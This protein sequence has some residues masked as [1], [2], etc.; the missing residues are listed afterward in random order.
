VC[1]EID[2]PLI[3]LRSCPIESIPMLSSHMMQRLLFVSTLLTA[4][5]MMVAV[6]SLVFTPRISIFWRLSAY[7]ILEPARSLG[8]QSLDWKNQRGIPLRMAEG[9]NENDTSSTQAPKRR[10]KRK[11]VTEQTTDDIPSKDSKELPSVAVEAPTI[12]QLKPRDDTPVTME[13]L[14]IRDVMGE[15]GGSSRSTK[16]ASSKGGFSFGQMPEIPSLSTTP[17]SSSSSSSSSFSSSS[18]RNVDDSLQQLLEDARMM[19]EERN[20]KSSSSSVDDDDESTGNIKSTIRNVLGNIVTADFFVVC[21]FLLWFLV[22]IFCSSVL[23]DDTIQ[24]AFNST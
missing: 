24:I 4:G 19:Q 11:I 20:Q 12:I 22:G 5:W 14:D 13:I 7:R 21:G 8:R 3:S 23:K 18:S 1:S 10:R 17:S 16:P 2:T 15:G 6:E 9:D